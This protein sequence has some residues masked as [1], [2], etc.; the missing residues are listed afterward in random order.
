MLITRMEKRKPLSDLDFKVCHM[1]RSQ[2]F[3]MLLFGTSPDVF[4]P[5]LSITPCLY[6]EEM[7]LPLALNG[8]L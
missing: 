6:G 2:G 3:T 7:A 4:Q 8:F 5:V 1:A